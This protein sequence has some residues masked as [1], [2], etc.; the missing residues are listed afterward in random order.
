MLNDFSISAKQR[1]LTYFIE[2]EPGLGLT[3]DNIKLSLPR[4]GIFTDKNTEVTVSFVNTL[5]HKPTTVGHYNRLNLQSYFKSNFG[6][7][8]LFLNTQPNI[9]AALAAVLS[10]YNTALTAEDV[11]LNVSTG[12]IT[13][14]ALPNSYGW[15]GSI[16]F[17][18]ASGGFQLDGDENFQLDDD[19]FF[20]LD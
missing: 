4:Q 20:E 9:D 6:G 2:Q 1:L 8:T 17:A 15:T 7:Q 14:L 10:E 3:N 18:T 13:L 16:S 12:N 11:S 5:M 19:T